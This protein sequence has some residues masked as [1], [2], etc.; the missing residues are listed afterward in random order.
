MS[1]P[2]TEKT[3]Q[4]QQSRGARRLAGEVTTTAWQVPTLGEPLD[5]L[6]QA[7]V[8]VPDPGDGEVLVEVWSAA[9]NF[10]DVLLMRG[11][12]QE[13]PGLPFTP[14]IE[15]CGEIVA[16]GPGV[17]PTRLGSRVVGTTLLPHGALAGYALARS[18]E[19]LPAPAAFDDA[20]ASAFVVAYHTAWFGLYRRAG[21]RVGETLLVHA[22]A[23]G[24][25][26]AAVQLGRLAGARVIAVVG[27]EEKADVAR[28]MGADLVIDR[29]RD[30]VIGAVKEATGEKGVDVIYDPV[31]GQAYTAS[32]KVVA[33]EGRIIVV[34]FA[35]GTIP[36]VTLNHA[37]VKNYSILGLHW[38]LYRSRR[39]ELIRR[40]HDELMT[41]AAADVVRPLVS[42]RLAFAEAPEGLAALAAGETIGRVTVSP[43]RVA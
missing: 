37:L 30:D 4:S 1:V 5:V 25:G 17:E 27:S 36:E 16:V 31:G 42:R 21:L 19:M 10:P 40:A 23:G 20:T 32:T 14:G 38:G 11:A 7:E 35:S 33:F 26:S 34:G 12:Y 41:M 28:E 43:P 15:L 3:R 24:T 8:S 39:P 2:A 6:Q 13:K 22:A 29:T 18:A 9:L